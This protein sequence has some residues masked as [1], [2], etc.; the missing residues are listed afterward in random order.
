MI[1]YYDFQFTC[2]S[3]VVQRQ[4][5][6]FKRR[7]QQISRAGDASGNEMKINLITFVLCCAF[8]EIE[9]YANEG[10]EE[11]IEKRWVLNA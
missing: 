7:L 5:S 3:S 11:P 9:C 8:F 10:E 1:I 2:V 6:Y 4:R